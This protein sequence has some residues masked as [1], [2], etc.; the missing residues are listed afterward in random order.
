MRRHA[1]IVAATLAAGFLALLAFHGERANTSMATFQPAGFMAHLTAADVRSIEVLAGA[2]RWQFARGGD[3]RWSASAAAS[4]LTP[5]LGA[6]LD[7]ALGL[8]R[9]AGAER[10]MTPAELGAQPLADFGLDPPRLSVTVRAG[11]SKTF[12]VSFGN[13][14]PIGLARYARIGGQ[15]GI[16]LLPGYVA[17]AWEKA[18]EAAQ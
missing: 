5:D 16:A 18:I 17:E 7:Q 10:V 11:A 9:N 6:R 12:S 3:G 14:N 1:W 2:Q 15:D 4:P 8:L 13:A